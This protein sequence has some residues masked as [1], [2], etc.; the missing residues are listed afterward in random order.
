MEP[1][2]VSRT[3]LIKIMKDYVDRMIT[4]Y[5][6]RKALVLDEETLGFVSICFSRSALLEKDVYLFDRI[7]RLGQEKLKH[8]GGIFFLR[9]NNENI[10]SICKEL[11]NPKFV[12]YYLFFSTPL[13]D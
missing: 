7:D 2:P 8:L 1:A 6:D 10:E 12:K 11:K 5:N 3:N 4:Q 13:S 9:A